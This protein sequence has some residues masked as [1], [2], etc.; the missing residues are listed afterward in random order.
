MSSQGS[1]VT[2]K[3]QMQ[4]D[5]TILFN[6]NEF[7]ETVTYKVNDTGAT[8]PIAA[9]IDI[10]ADLGVTAQGRG[11]TGTATIKGSD[12][13][14]P[15]IYDEMTTT[16]GRIWRVESIIGGDGITW[17]LFVTSDNRAVPR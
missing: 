15:E 16:T 3:T 14:R 13:A 7:A 11:M 12:I 5:L 4:A 17:N 6:T 2:L 9:I 10:S 8:K 1:N